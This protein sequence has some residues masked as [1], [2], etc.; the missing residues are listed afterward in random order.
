MSGGVRLDGRLRTVCALV[1]PGVAVADIGTDHGYVP[2]W[3]VQTGCTPRAIACDIHRAPLEKARRAVAA[4][5][6]CRQIDCRLGPG[7]SPVAPGE[8][9]EVVIAGMGGEL[10]ADILSQCSWVRSPQVG[11]VLQPMTKAPVLRRFLVE[12]GF[13]I[14]DERPAA[15]AGRDYT[16]LRSRYTG[17]AQPC[18]LLYALTGQLPG[19]PG[20]QRYLGHVVRQLQLQLQS[21]RLAPQQ[22]QELCQTLAALQ[23]KQ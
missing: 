12:N 21:P 17:A 11:L 20:A 14:E 8:V 9:E 23:K 16:V 7:L 10:I 3:L 6:L 22:R 2:I 13:V 5:G 18:S 4:A 15:A 1:R 19:K